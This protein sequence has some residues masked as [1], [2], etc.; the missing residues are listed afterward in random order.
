MLGTFDG[1]GPKS[2]LQEQLSGSWDP[3]GGSAGAGKQET[4][5]NCQD[6]EPASIAPSWIRD[7]RA[8]SLNLPGKLDFTR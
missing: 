4:C 1:F 6:Q 7:H 2:G 3:A 8:F 5:Q